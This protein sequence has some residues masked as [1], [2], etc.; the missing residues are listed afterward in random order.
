MWSF[1][2]DYAAWEG[3]LKLILVPSNKSDEVSL[4]KTL[5]TDC[6]WKFP[7]YGVRNKNLIRCCIG[8]ILFGM[9]HKV[10]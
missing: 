5:S 7:F 3:V 6:G 9:L 8:L 10:T 4:K 2:S 1:G